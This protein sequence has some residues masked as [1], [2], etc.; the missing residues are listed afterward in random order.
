MD[1][2]VN[3]TN[4][5]ANA[6]EN[7][8]DATDGIVDTTNNHVDPINRH[9]NAGPGDSDRCVDNAN[10]GETS[11]HVDN[12]TPDRTNRGIDN[13]GPDEPLLSPVTTVDH[14]LWVSDL[15]PQ[16]LT[17]ALKQPDDQCKGNLNGLWNITPGTMVWGIQ[18]EYIEDL[19]TTTV[20]T[21]SEGDPKRKE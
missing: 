13:T 12:A 7:Q 1:G 9:D 10:P 11:R 6:R 17:E 21:Y 14:I 5:L 18:S 19:V 3:M 8:V 16:I 2:C 4:D 15:E 20:H